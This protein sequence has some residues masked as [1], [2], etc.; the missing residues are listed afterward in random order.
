MSLGWVVLMGCIGA[1]ASLDMQA[2]KATKDMSFPQQRV[3]RQQIV[4][5]TLGGL[6]ALALTFPYESDCFLDLCHF[7]G[8][9]IEFD[10]DAEGPF[11]RAMILSIPFLLGFSTQLAMSIID[12]LNHAV[13]AF[14]GQ[15]GPGTKQVVGPSPQQS[16]H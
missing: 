1:I 8:T 12:Q 16:D 11:T 4:R 7:I 15:L 2:I 10:G 14:F 5:V 3:T 9:G 13:S 6:L